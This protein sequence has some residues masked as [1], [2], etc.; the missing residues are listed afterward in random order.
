MK[1]KYGFVTI[2]QATKVDITVFEIVDS[3]IGD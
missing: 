2:F 3:H 1:I